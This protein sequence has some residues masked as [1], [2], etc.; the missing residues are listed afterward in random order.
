[1]NHQNVQEQT[2]DSQPFD[3]NT[4]DIRDREKKLLDTY[5]M[6]GEDQFKLISVKKASEIPVPL[7]P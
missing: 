1:M 3:P 6:A 7:L 4:V 5:N 2:V